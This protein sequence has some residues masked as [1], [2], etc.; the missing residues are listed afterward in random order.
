MN[1]LEQQDQAHNESFQMMQTLMNVFRVPGSAPQ[2]SEGGR[3]G[4]QQGGSQ[5][6]QQRL[7]VTG[8]D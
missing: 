5:P 3:G 6:R 8:D 1:Y 2:Q 4:G 7:A